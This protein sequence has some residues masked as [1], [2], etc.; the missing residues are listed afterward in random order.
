[1]AVG[2]ISLLNEQRLKVLEG[3]HINFF[4]D[5]GAFE[6]WNEKI[7]KFSHLVKFRV[8]DLLEKMNAEEGTDIADYLTGS[9]KIEEQNS[10]KEEPKNL[11][12][13]LDNDKGDESSAFFIT[14]D[15]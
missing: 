15:W 3:R 7:I 4:P 6:K 1:M 11:I 10:K 13:F 12:S 14:D 8:S 2:G 5:K 9:Y